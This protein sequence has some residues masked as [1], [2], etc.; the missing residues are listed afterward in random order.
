MK[1][2]KID[3]PPGSWVPGDPPFHT[4]SGRQVS[5]PA[6]QGEQWIDPMWGHGFFCALLT[7][8]GDTCPEDW[9]MRIPDSVLYMT[10]RFAPPPDDLLVPIELFS[11][12]QLRSG[13]MF[14][15]PERIDP[16]SI[17]CQGLLRHVLAR[18][19][20]ALFGA[21]TIEDAQLTWGFHN[22]VNPIEQFRNFSETVQYT[23]DTL[24]GGTPPGWKLLEKHPC[25]NIKVHF[26]SLGVLLME[27]SDSMRNHGTM[28]D[29]WPPVK[30]YGACTAYG[31]QGTVLGHLARKFSLWDEASAL[32]D[33]TDLPQVDPGRNDHGQPHSGFSLMMVEAYLQ[34]DLGIKALATCFQNAWL[35]MQRFT[36]MNRHVVLVFADEWGLQSSTTVGNLVYYCLTRMGF[37]T[38][39]LE[40]LSGN[41]HG[42]QTCTNCSC[43]VCDVPVENMLQEMLDRVW[44]IWRDYVFKPHIFWGGDPYRLPPIGA[45]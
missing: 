16:H 2:A 44:N 24:Y 10:N 32:V 45:R 13:T 1:K 22:I 17:S 26:Y 42:P 21:R 4:W 14:P 7:S 38:F 41:F 29:R 39:R 19:P 28:N 6:K 36:P 8:P 5:V 33:C 34:N 40:C 15:I 23:I 3:A 18:H 25:C 35:A 30:F 11:L 12:E 37:K 27:N 20:L 9:V 43:R 31:G